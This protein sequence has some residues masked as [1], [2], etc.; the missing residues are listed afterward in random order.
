MSRASR[1]LL[2]LI[3]VLL[4]AVILPFVLWGELFESSFSLAGARAWM[5]RFGAW[6]WLAGIGLLIADV[7]L[8]IPGTVVMS[9]MGWMYGWL[10]GGVISAAGSVLS[11]A[12]AYWLCRSLGR[13]IAVKIAGED[14]LEQAHALFEKSGGWLVAVSRWLPVLPEAVACL[15]GLAR[16]RWRTFWVALLCGSLPLGFAFAAIGDLGHESPAAA[17]ALSAVVPVGMWWVARR[18]RA[19]Q[20]SK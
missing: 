19:V 12:A 9:A 18:W 16:M 11:G 10:L 5:E 1:H 3:L 17:L 20:S 2:A 13:P 4:V 15:A 8:P 7:G 14:G 6:A